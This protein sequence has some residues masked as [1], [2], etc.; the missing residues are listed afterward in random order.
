[1]D[2]EWRK[3]ISEIRRLLIQASNISQIYGQPTRTQMLDIVFGKITVIL[4]SWEAV[5][6]D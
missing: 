2:K 5:N 3:D 6:V 1:M 4:D